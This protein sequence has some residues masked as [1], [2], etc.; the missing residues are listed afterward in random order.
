[1][2]IKT[3]CERECY[4]DKFKLMAAVLPAT[5]RHMN[6][7]LPLLPSGP[8]GVHNLSLREDQ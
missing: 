6:R 1:M 4:I 2:L 3:L 7:L 8:G 5:S